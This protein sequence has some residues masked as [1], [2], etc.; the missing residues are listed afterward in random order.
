[1]RSNGVSWVALPNTKLDYASKSE[2]ALLRGGRV[3]GLSLVWSSPQWKL[4]KVVGSPGLVSGPGR[5]LALDPDH[6][7]L[8][9]RQ[10]SVLTVR[11]RYTN[12]W[13]LDSKAPGAAP[14]CV[15]PGPDGWTDVVAKQAGTLHLVV[16]VFGD[17]S[18][19]CP[20]S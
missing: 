6:V 5:L 19:N 12:L 9:I 4:W 7:S 2:D 1:L 16:S 3:P 15:R 11:I 17:Q 14:A 10:P 20:G 13:S 18:A 8:S